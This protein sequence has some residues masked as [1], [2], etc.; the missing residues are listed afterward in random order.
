VQALNFLRNEVSSVVNHNDMEESL[1]FR[2]LVE[3]LLPSGSISLPSVPVVHQTDVTMEDL[4]NWTD[5]LDEEGDELVAGS[6]PEPSTPLSD[7]LCAIEDPEEWDDATPSSRS[8]SGALYAQRM[9]VFES[10]LDF[11]GD[12]YRQPRKGLME[13]IDGAYWR[14]AAK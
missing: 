4:P 2:A 12:K 14:N 13:L 11:I 1:E 5:K 8:V 10:L 3:H 7:I 6:S 9:E